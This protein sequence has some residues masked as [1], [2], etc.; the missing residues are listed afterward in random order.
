MR[1]VQ[2]PASTLK[3]PPALTAAQPALPTTLLTQVTNTTTI[4]GR[5]SFAAPAIKGKPVTNMVVQKLV[6]GPYLGASQTTTN[7]KV[8]EDTQTYWGGGPGQLKSLHM[9]ETDVTTAR[10]LTAGAIVVTV[11]SATGTT[12]K[13][14]QSYTTNLTEAVTSNESSMGQ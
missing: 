6:N 4:G 1:V 14:K 8:V 7:S 2:H 12:N 9:T 3:P 13:I 5:I 11:N 10:T